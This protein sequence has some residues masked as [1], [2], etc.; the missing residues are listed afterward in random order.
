MNH[1]SI[2]GFY[3]VLSTDAGIDAI[4]SSIYNTVPPDGQEA[5]YFV[6]QLVDETPL[7]HV[8]GATTARAQFQIDFF[9]RDIS[10]CEDALAAIRTALSPDHLIL[11]IQRTYNPGTD[12]FRVSVDLSSTVSY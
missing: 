10:N 3:T 7:N 2:Q 8:G 6:F 12:N 5:P 4:S 11:G 1:T 9:G